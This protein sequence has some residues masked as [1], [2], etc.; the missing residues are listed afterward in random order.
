D[1][2]ISSHKSLQFAARVVDRDAYLERG[3]VVLLDAHRSDL[4]DLAAEALVLERFHLD[5]SGLSKIDFADIALVDFAIDVNLLHI[6]E[7]H[8]KRCRG[9]Q[10]QNGTDSVANFYATRETKPVE[11][12]ADGRVLKLFG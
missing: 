7:G 1:L 3:Y 9:A 2:G 6:A 5:A 12:S 10:A 11:G 8:D 4:R